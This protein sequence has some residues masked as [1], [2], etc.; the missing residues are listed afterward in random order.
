MTQ[1]EINDIDRSAALKLESELTQPLPKLEDLGLGSNDPTQAD[2][3]RPEQPPTV[4]VDTD[5]MGQ[6]IAM[7]I[8]KGENL[9]ALLAGVTAWGMTEAQKQIYV[10]SLVNNFVIELGLQ[11][12]GF[13]AALE[14]II[15]DVIGTKNGQVN[16][17]HSLGIGALIL[18]AGVFMTRKAVLE[19]TA[20]DG[21]ESAV[22]GFNAGFG[23]VDFGK[24]AASQ[25][26][27]SEGGKTR[28]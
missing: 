13:D 27:S 3:T 4:D 18:G 9:R 8:P 23:G 22:G 15:C 28:E 20:N 12:I 26:A 10:T 14:K 7:N 24:N 16:P 11:T 2:P 1:P 19:G 6:L 5:A 17:L 21:T 25:T